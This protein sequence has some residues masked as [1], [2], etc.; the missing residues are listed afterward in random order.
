MCRYSEVARL[1]TV[2]HVLSLDRGWIDWIGFY[3]QN[4]MQKAGAS[5]QGRGCDVMGWDAG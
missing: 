3:M 1:A 5:C 4:A 2:E